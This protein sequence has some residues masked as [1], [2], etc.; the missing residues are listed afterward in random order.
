MVPKYNEATVVTDSGLILTLPSDREV[1]M[2]RVFDAP[3]Q[4]V[5]EAHVVCERVKEWWGPRGYRL[6]SCEMDLRP[7]GPWRF[8]QHGPDDK[9]YAFRGEYLEIV[10]PERLV[11][12]FE[13]EGMPGYVSLETLTLVEQDGKT[14][15]TSHSLF[16][17]TEARDGM[18]GSGM[19]AGARETW[20]RLAEHLEGVSQP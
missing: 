5:F 10:A 9:E 16:D 11:Q 14:T 12:T 13:F 3:R 18:L 1:E 19:E 8:V 7:G 2:S 4:L 15:L 6:V 17:S 20:D